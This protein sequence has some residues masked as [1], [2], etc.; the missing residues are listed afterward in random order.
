MIHRS[1]AS[2]T[3]EAVSC[4]ASIKE[5]ANMQNSNRHMKEACIN[6]HI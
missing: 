5:Q 1:G 6:E 2:D 3:K 4:N